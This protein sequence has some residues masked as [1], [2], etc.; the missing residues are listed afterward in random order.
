MIKRGKK[1]KMP[2]SGDCSFRAIAGAAIVAALIVA[3]VGAIV[4]IFLSLSQWQQ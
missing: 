4:L 3:I 1:G 2:K